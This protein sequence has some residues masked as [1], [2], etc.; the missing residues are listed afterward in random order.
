M[1]VNY[2]VTLQVV[3]PG[4][5]F[6][7]VDVPLGGQGHPTTTWKRNETVREDLPLGVDPGAPRGHYRLIVAV[8]DPATVER[9]PV[10]GPEGQVLGDAFELGEVIVGR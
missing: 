9:L 4:R 2:V 6:G 7:Q 10:V 5:L 8:Y 1:P 3:G